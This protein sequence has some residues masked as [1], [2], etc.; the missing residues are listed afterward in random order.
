MEIL[1]SLY[2]KIIMAYHY[3]Y[4]IYVALPQFWLNS[5]PFLHQKIFFKV[6]NKHQSGLPQDFVSLLSPLQFSALL[7]SLEP[8]PQVLEHAVQED[9]LQSPKK[10]YFET[11]P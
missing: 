8:I 3:A 4:I 1:Y 6:S 5:N 11:Y 9:Q 7:L 2:S 10:T